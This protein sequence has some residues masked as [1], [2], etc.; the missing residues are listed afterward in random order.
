MIATKIE[1]PEL[2]VLMARVRE[3]EVQLAQTRLGFAQ[4]ASIIENIKATRGEDK[5]TVV[6]KM[7]GNIM[8][9]KIVG[10]NGTEITF[11]G[12]KVSV[13]MSKAV[14]FT[15]PTTSQ[16]HQVATSPNN[17]LHDALHKWTLEILNAEKVDPFY[18]NDILDI[19]RYLD[20]YYRDHSN[21]KEVDK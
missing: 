12:D 9:D 8:A 6:L 19:I 3:L 20:Q 21:N 16:V 15:D 2:E 5:N 4:V 11:D 10:K 7:D 1:I 13:A 18:V 14:T 17:E